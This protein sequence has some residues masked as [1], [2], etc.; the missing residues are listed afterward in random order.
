MISNK[1]IIRYLLF[2]LGGVLYEI[3]PAA[4][5]NS[6]INLSAAKEVLRKISFDELAQMDIFTDFEKGRLEPNQ[7]RAM[8]CNT[9]KLQHHSSAF[10][11][12]WNSILIKPYTDILEFAAKQSG[13]Y[14]ICLLSNTNEIHYNH[15][16]PK[17]REYLDKFHSCFYSFRLGLRKPDMSIF[18]HILDTLNVPPEEILFIDD[19]ISNIVSAEGTGMQTYYFDYNKNKHI[20]FNEFNTDKTKS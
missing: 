12:A 14:Q 6:L 4:L 17:C 13:K 11:E 20:L 9:F 5:L 3:N 18:R 19:T 10:D 16:Y 15:F 2:D 1:N 7:F 8:V